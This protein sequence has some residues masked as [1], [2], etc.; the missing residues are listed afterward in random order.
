MTY[1][2]SFTYCDTIQTIP[3]PK[4]PQHNIIMPLQVLRP[5][6]IPSNYS[7]S[8]ACNIM[9]LDLSKEHDIK[10][11]FVSPS[12]A[13]NDRHV[14]AKIKINNNLPASSSVPGIQFN[15]DMR[16]IVLSEEGIH[17]TV[18]YVDEAKI[19]EYKIM[20]ERG[21]NNGQ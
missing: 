17:T 3:T 14:E 5:V 18:I 11:D 12:G 20:V 16:N 6:N 2:S 1:V 8:I 4:G 7:F 19:G 9:G 21:G 10:L 15:I 13:I